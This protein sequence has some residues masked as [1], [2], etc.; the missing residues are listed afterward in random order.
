MNA[1]IQSEISANKTTET[2]LTEVDKKVLPGGP[3]MMLA[4]PG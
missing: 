1:A 4:I 2:N 3:D